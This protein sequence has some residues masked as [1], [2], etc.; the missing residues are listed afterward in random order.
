MFFVVA[1]LSFILLFLGM[2][3]LFRSR[4]TFDNILFLFLISNIL[5]IISSSL[6]I[7]KLK[8]MLA[9][10]LLGLSFGFFQMFRTFIFA[11][12]GWEDLTGIIYLISFAAVG[13]FLGSVIQLFQ[14]IFEAI[15]EKKE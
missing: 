7:L 14:H 15:S 5:G 3:Y 8:I 9:L 11:R 10:Y 4:I 2:Y 12:T 1:P 13:L 6:Y